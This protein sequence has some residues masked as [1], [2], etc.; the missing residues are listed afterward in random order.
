MH[1]G[2][3]STQP[4][5]ARA[6]ISVPVPTAQPAEAAIA[7]RAMSASNGGAPAQRRAIIRRPLRSDTE[8]H[9]RR[10]WRGQGASSPAARSRSR[11]LWPSTAGIR[12]TTFQRAG[13]R[14]CRWSHAVR[15]HETGGPEV[16]KWEPVEVGAP[17]PGEV[18]ARASGPS[19]SISSTSI[20]A[21]GLYKLARCRRCIGMEGAGDVVAV[22]RGRHGS[23][24]RRPRR[25][26]GR[27]RR[28]CRGA[29]DRRRPS[30]EAAGCHRLRDR[31]GDDAAA[32]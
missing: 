14:S 16:L 23:Q 19:A 1:S 17:G 15:I 3:S 30:G 2:L 6:S 5:P 12:V 13:Q 26:C 32:A 28:L 10:P 8:R 21:R 22:G 9:R 18:R 29:P 11:T 20:T 4:R 24:G 7:A 31:R 27:A 25:L